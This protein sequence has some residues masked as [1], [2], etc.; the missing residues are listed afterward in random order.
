MK[1]Y[2]L[3]PASATPIEHRCVAIRSSAE[4]LLSASKIQQTIFTIHY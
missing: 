3:I 2:V 4:L 1:K